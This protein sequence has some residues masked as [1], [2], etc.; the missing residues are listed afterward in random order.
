MAKNI[1]EYVVSEVIAYV[2]DK[3]KDK[4]TIETIYDNLSVCLFA[5]KNGLNLRRLFLV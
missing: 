5:G 4:K 2:D 3:C 1:M